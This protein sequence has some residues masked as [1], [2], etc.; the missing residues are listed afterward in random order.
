MAGGVD[1][2]LARHGARMRKA[3]T[4]ILLA[5]ALVPGAVRP[6]EAGPIGDAVTAFGGWIERVETWASDTWNRYI[7]ADGID[8]DAKQLARMVVASPDRFDTLAGLAGFTFDGYDLPMGGTVDMRLR[9]R[10]SHAL[11]ADERTALL[12][13]VSIH[14][15]AESRGNG[16]PGR[17]VLKILSEAADWRD[18]AGDTGFVVR[19]VTLVVNDT[20]RAYLDYGRTDGK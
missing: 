20:V 12:R 8:I 16:S 14:E 7:L 9:F 2:I 13:A 1:T 17:G 3:I 10:H 4:A 18:A 19:G 11:S 15:R 5:T 6:S